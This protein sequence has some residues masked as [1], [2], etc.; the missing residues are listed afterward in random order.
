MGRG[1]VGWRS[2]GVEEEGVGQRTRSDGEGVW[3]E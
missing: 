2:D 3:L 1:R